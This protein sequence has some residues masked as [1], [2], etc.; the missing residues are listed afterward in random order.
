MA[1]IASADTIRAQLADDAAAFQPAGDPTVFLA[2]KPLPPNS[3]LALRARV[4]P[5]VV[6]HGWSTILV[7]PSEHDALVDRGL[8]LPEPIDP[9]AASTGAEAR[10]LFESLEQQL[11]EDLDDESGLDE[12]RSALAEIGEP[13]PADEAASAFHFESHEKSVRLLILPVSEH[14]TVAAL[15]FGG[16][17]DAPDEQTNRVVHAY[18]RGLYGAVP[19]YVGG[20][21]L[22]FAVARPPTT[23]SSLRKLC[24]EQYVYCNDIVE[25]GTQTL[26]GLALEL[27]KH[28][29]FFWWD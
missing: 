8:L 2:G 18:W 6:A 27:C 21:Y 15:G 12:H 16:F 24:W 3:A 29:W 4:H 14:L 10:A 17:N 22:E 23:A 13:S 9:D 7:D 25:Q 26:D 5:R 1:S 11:I 28:Q 19:V 20:D